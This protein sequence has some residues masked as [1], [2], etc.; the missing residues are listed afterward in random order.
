MT[1]MLIP[2]NITKDHVMI[3]IK[4]AFKR[5]VLIKIPSNAPTKEVMITRCVPETA[6]ICPIPLRY[7]IFF[8]AGSISLLSPHI[9]A[10]RKPDSSYVPYCFKVEKT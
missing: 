5:F 8:V 7:S 2:A 10:P 3:S 4:T 1:E 6:K 9:I